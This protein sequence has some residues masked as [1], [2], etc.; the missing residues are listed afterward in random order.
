MAVPR[1]PVWLGLASFGW[2]VVGWV[3]AA[4]A[5]HLAFV[6]SVEVLHLLLPGITAALI[7]TNLAFS[8]NAL[9]RRK[10]PVERLLLVTGLQIG[11]F[12]TLFFQIA[13]HLGAD[14]YSIQRPTRSWEWVQFSVAHAIR[15]ADV[16]DA[17]EAYGWDIQVIKH[18][19]PFVASVVVAYHVIVDLF[20]LGLFWAMTRRIKE[21]LLENPTRV[22]VVFIL[23]ALS[24]LVW[25][26]VWMAF[27]MEVRPWRP[28]DVL[29]WFAENVVRVVDFADAMD[30]FDIHWHQVPAG[31]VESTLTFFCRLWIAIGISLALNWRMARKGVRPPIVDAGPVSPWSLARLGIAAVLIA[32]LI[33]A[34]AA[35]EAGTS[36]QIAD[37]VSAATGDD[38]DR[39]EKSLAAIR[40]LGPNAQVAIGPL[41]EARSRLPDRSGKIVETLGHL[42]PD[43]VG[44]LQDIATSE[45]GAEAEAA[46]ASLRR[47]GSKAAPALA[48]VA[49]MTQ[50]G[51]VKT[52][53]ATGLRDLGLEAMPALIEATDKA[54]STV[55]L[56]WFNELDRNWTLRAS[57][58]KTFRALVRLQKYRD[59]MQ[60]SYGSRV[61]GDEFMAQMLGQDFVTVELLNDIRD[62]GTP[63]LLV[64]ITA[65][66][67][68]DRE[69]RRI[70]IEALGE[71]GPRAA[72]A[73]SN[74]RN[75]LDATHMSLPA[76][77][78]S[79]NDPVIR[80][81]AALALG[82]IGPRASEAEKALVTALAD[83]DE[84]LRG[85][86]AS[87]LGAIRP[88]G[89]EAVSALVKALTDKNGEVRRAA[90]VALGMYGRK[91]RAALPELTKLSSD[92]KIIGA[93]E[94]R[95]AIGRIRGE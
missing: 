71:L 34:D 61:V 74:L 50:K 59:T 84:E 67:K 30:S 17:I 20:V 44:S 49:G 66:W 85:A 16:L 90:S 15:A 9:F 36:A 40:R 1:Y 77:T 52:A 57:D 95:D 51:R 80:R 32:A 43:V 86:A 19:R 69:V 68:K 13:A 89:G 12:T 39:A 38:Q 83:E 62:C 55:H 47:I 5:P 10:V 14:H 54:N 22:A 63:G 27:A 42:G 76:R 48:A 78:F 91:A 25:F 29:L 79:N 35:L 65:L 46:V 26:G 28:I 60:S 72:R 81:L 2:A 33:G 93:S 31:P 56:H 21:R 4:S 3:L 53:A 82:K 73:E 24:F 11:L 58:N 94:A 88:R 6:P 70:A 7:L 37:L 23:G 45:K 8:L 92:D 41:A 18:R 75:S 87:A 64:F